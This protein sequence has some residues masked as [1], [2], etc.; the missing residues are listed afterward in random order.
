MNIA[1]LISGQGSN[2]QALLDD[3]ARQ[4]IDG[5]ISLVISNRP[6]VAGLD[7]AAAAGVESQVIDHREFESREAFDRALVAALEPHRP[8]LVILAGF[9]RILTPEFI[10]P[11]QGRLLNIHPSLLPKYPGLNTHQRAL[12]AGDRWAGA[13]VHFVT[14]ELD[15]GPPVVFARVPVAPDDTAESLALRVRQREYQIYPLAAAWICAGR[16]SLDASGARLDGELLPAMGVDAM[17]HRY[18]EFSARDCAVYGIFRL[19]S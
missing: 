18:L 10:A 12:D 19:R 5:R 1:V 16:L 3:C 14:E 9:M 13:T 2:L 15:G 4:R 7:R 11:Y 8:D 6:G 17:S